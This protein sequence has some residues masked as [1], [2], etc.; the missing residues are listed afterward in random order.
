MYIEFLL[1]AWSQRKPSVI[2]CTIAGFPPNCR[3][4]YY[5]G[6]SENVRQDHPHRP[7]RMTDFLEQLPDWIERS[8]EENGKMAQIL[9]SLFVKR[10]CRTVHRAFTSTVAFLCRRHCNAL[11][12]ILCQHYNASQI[13]TL[14]CRLGSDISTVIGEFYFIDLGQPRL[15]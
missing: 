6:V 1:F 3:Y 11:I 4:G 15:P 9:A 14:Q 8:A 10:L 7:W 2:L 5:L 12:V 13:F